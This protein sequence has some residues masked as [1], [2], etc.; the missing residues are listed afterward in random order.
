MFPSYISALWIATV[1]GMFPKECVQ[2]V[3]VQESY[4]SLLNVI[5]SVKQA[6]ANSLDYIG[7]AL[8]L[9]SFMSHPKHSGKS[10]ASVLPQSM[11]SA[12]LEL[13]KSSSSMDSHAIISRITAMFELQTSDDI[14]SVLVSFAH[15]LEPETHRLASILNTL[16][17]DRE[18]LHSSLQGEYPA[19]IDT[20]EYE[21]A[22][23][24]SKVRRISSQLES[25]KSRFPSI[26]Q[27]ILSDVPT[28]IHSH[29]FASLEQ[30]L[31]QVQSELDYKERQIDNI[32][33]LQENNPL[34]KSLSLV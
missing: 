22:I 23:L 21:T 1:S 7:T 27:C 10:V 9:A 17:S 30:E 33:I 25:V 20:M 28:V 34:D 24:Q 2:L 13:F 18:S 16:Q 14:I 12:I 19:C 31:V 8:G 4:D 6:E 26:G 3:K 29:Y 11:I 32:K 15:T 5:V